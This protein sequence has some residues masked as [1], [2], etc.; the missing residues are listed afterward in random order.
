MKSYAL[1]S[2]WERYNR[3]PEHIRRLAD[4][5]FK[6]FSQNPRHP[7]LDF[8]KKGAVHTAEVGRH[9]RAIAR[10]RDGDYYW[11]WIG[12]HEEYNKFTL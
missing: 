7:S 8:K 12:S 4:K 2:F 1:P 6:L 11:F 10:E 5:N 9:Y 3:L